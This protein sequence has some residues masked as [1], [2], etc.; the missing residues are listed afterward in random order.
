[1][2]STTFPRFISGI[3]G[4]NVG[5]SSS[6]TG[7]TGD[8]LGPALT[9]TKMVIKIEN[10]AP[11]SPA[12][13]YAFAVRK[14]NG[15]VQDLGAACTIP[16]GSSTCTFTGSVATGVGDELN[17]HVSRTGSTSASPGWVLWTISYS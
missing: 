15:T 13:T 10:A 3:S 8:V 16:A 5:N 1:V 6:G 2:T 12:T 7:D 9:I 17:L 11:A 14:T 4:F